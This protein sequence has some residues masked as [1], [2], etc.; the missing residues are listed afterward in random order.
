[1]GEQKNPTIEIGV[2]VIEGEDVF[3]IKDNGIGIAPEFHDRIF[4]LFNKL[5]QFAE[6]TGIGLALVKRIVEVH[7]GKIW[8]ESELGNGATFYFTLANQKLE[9]T[10]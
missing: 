10:V 5:D 8:V 2:K 4:G 9:E 6:G 7:G 3:F 1:M